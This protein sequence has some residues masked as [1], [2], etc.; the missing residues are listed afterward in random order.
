MPCDTLPSLYIAT[1]TE[2]MFMTH[3]DHWHVHMKGLR[4]VAERWGGLKPGWGYVLDKVRKYVVD[5][6]TMFD[7]GE[8]LHANT[9]YLGRI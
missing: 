9:R 4:S 2:Q 1:D 7:G 8:S 5:N 6:L 3:F